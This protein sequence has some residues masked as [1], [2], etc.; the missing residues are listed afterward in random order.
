[1]AGVA[2][3]DGAGG[4]DDGRWRGGVGV[5][6]RVEW[7]GKVGADDGRTAAA[8]SAALSSAWRR[9]MVSLAVLVVRCDDD[10]DERATEV[11]VVA[12]PVG[13]RGDGPVVAGGGGGGGIR[14][15]ADVGGILAGVSPPSICIPRSIATA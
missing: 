2:N 6:G 10:D 8:V 9:T 7:V 14:R 1:M 5:G 11:P 3:A 15:P 13:W 4:R 12:P